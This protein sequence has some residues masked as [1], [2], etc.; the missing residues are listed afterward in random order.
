M[1][2]QGE[3][4][5][6]APRCNCQGCKACAKAR[7]CPREASEGDQRCKACH[8]QAALDWAAAVP[9][10]PVAFPTW[11]TWQQRAIRYGQR[12]REYKR[13]QPVWFA[14]NLII[15]FSSP[16][17]GLALAGVTGVA[18]GLVFAVLSWVFGERASTRIVERDR[19]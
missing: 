4:S 9:K 3:N 11:S 5:D 12:V 10:L 14:L 17:L 7:P 18:A 19:G 8:D 2:G 1:L 13:R 16:F 15:T 6:V